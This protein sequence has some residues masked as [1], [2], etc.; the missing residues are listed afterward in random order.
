MSIYGMGCEGLVAGCS[1]SKEIEFDAGHRVPNH[2]SKCQ[3]PH[4]HRYRVVMHVSGDLVGTEGDSQE[5]MV[6]DFGFMKELLTKHVHDVFDHGFIVHIKDTV[7]RDFLLN[8]YPGSASGIGLE[9]HDEWKVIVF[10]LV[11]TA[12]NLAMWIW[13]HL[14]QKVTEI[15]A[16]RAWLTSIE[17][18]ETPSSCATYGNQ[19]R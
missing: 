3:N 16:T 8:G 7:L 18:W 13:D 4:G 11:P 12:E 2:E 5:G 1:I 6:L 15:T 19:P 9:G 17:V 10:P 14:A